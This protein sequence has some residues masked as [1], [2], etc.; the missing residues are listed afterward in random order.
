MVTLKVIRSGA[1]V[2]VTIYKE[3][4]ANRL[5]TTLKYICLEKNTRQATSYC[6]SLGKHHQLQY[7]D[8]TQLYIT[9]QDLWEWE[10]CAWGYYI[11]SSLNINKHVD[12]VCCSSGFHVVFFNTAVDSL[13]L[14]DSAKSVTIVLW[15]EPRARIDYCNSILYNATAQGNVDKLQRIQNLLTGVVVSSCRTEPITLIL[16]HRWLPISNRIHYKITN[17]QGHQSDGSLFH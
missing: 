9:L 7:A 11:N 14:C 6:T 8:D 2:C 4:V 10:E 5:Y 17:T 3:S 16:D 15:S 13:T 12:G 1:S